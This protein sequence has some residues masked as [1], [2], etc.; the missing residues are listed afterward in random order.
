[1]VGRTPEYFGKKI[2]AKEIK[3]VIL[4]I[5]APCAIIL[6]GSGIACVLPIG[7]SSL[8]NRGPHGLTEIMYAFTSAAGNNGS[9][10]AG[11]NAN[12]NFYNLALAFTMLIGRFAIKVPVLAIAG[13]LVTKKV[14]PVSVGTFST[15][16][17]VFALLLVSVI[18]IVGALTFLPGLSLGPII[19]QFLMN[20]GRVF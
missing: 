11:L 2:E 9:A 17:F 16:N 7:L 20:S 13:S 15:D 19:E 1:M 6:I 12:T 4:A 14:A 3:M 8:A 18:L 10:F 5:I